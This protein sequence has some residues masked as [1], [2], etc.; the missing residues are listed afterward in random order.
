MSGSNLGILEAR[1]SSSFAAG[2][3]TSGRAGNCD[4]AKELSAIEADAAATG[5]IGVAGCGGRSGSLGPSSASCCCCCVA[6][7]CEADACG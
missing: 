6:L 5:G 1:S 4:F 7:N 2:V 3:A